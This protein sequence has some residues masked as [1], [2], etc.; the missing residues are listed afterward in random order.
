VPQAAKIGRPDARLSAA[1]PAALERLY[2]GLEW[3]DLVTRFLTDPENRTDW[4][5]AHSLAGLG[6][7]R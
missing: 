4:V 5:K 7:A 2:I 1:A 3:P 6:L